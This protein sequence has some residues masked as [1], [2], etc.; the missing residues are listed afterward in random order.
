MEM[1]QVVEY[2]CRVSKALSLS[3]A[4]RGPLSTVGYGS[5]RL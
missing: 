5:G 1:S 3:W 2:M 4:S